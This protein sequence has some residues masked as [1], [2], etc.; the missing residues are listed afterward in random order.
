M[1]AGRKELKRR[2]TRTDGKKRQ[3]TGNRENIN[4]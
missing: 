1:K 4:K 2:N 3:E